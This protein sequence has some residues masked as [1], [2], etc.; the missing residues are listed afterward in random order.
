MP[1]AFAEPLLLHTITYTERVCCLQQYSQ[2]V[3]AYITLQTICSLTESITVLP[4][5]H[6]DGIAYKDVKVPCKKCNI[7]LHAE[8]YH[9]K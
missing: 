6:C 4:R 3:A 9:F 8:L 7:C 2:E 5:A 1:L